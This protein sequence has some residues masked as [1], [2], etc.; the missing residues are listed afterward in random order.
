MNRRS[1]L[2]RGGAALTAAALPPTAWGESAPKPAIRFGACVV[3]LPQAR[4]AGL[5]GIEP[6]VGGPADLLDIS[7]PEVRQRYHAQM[8][9]TGLSVCSL[10]MGLL[11]SNPLAT[12]PR[13]PV[14]LDQSIDAA[15]DLG[16]KVILV[17]FFGAGDLL[18]G[19]S[20][21]KETEA[22]EVVRRLKAAAPK[23]KEA[24]VI[25][26]IENM[27]NGEQNAR[28][29]DRVNHES[30]Q[31]YYDVYNT[32]TSKGHNVPADLKLLKGRL[33]QLHFKNG[34]KYL[35]EEPAKFEPITAAVKEIGYRGWIV[36]ETSSPSGNAV[37][38]VR[39]NAEYLRK[40]LA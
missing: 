33:A 26:G 2:V 10:M 30:V 31:V 28:L 16:A 12:D 38:D 27:L 25:L 4:E 15:R 18:D 29:L 9:E 20:Q 19:K 22:D 3:G 37:A 21:L 35:D 6:G 17:A 34:P 1:F 13:A 14:W 5:E 40:L 24:G 11:N 36:L 23:A 7:K 39:R 8:K 32:G